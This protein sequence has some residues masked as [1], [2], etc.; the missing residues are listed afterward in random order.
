[1][2]PIVRAGQRN[3][4]STN[5]SLF[6]VAAVGAPEGSL[7]KQSLRSV[8]GQSCV[9]VGVEHP[10]AAR[11]RQYWI[12]GGEAGRGERDRSTRVQSKNSKRNSGDSTTLCLQLQKT[13]RTDGAAAVVKRRSGRDTGASTWGRAS[14]SDLQPSNVSLTRYAHRHRVL[15]PNPS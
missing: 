8:G 4:Q 13:Q 5:G 11:G 12:A 10:G 7:A 14:C 1:M 3:A 9:R 15:G 6:L 2:P